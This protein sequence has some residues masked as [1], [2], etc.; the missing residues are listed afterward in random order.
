MI[1]KLLYASTARFD[2]GE[3]ELMEL[4]DV[5]RRNNARDAISGLLLYY[6][7]TFLQLLEGESDLVEATHARISKDPRHDSL[8]TLVDDLYPARSFE[9]WTMGFIPK[10]T[11][12][13]EQVEG[14]DRFLMSGKGLPGTPEADAVLELIESFR[15]TVKPT[16]E[17]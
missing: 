12:L 15:A 16:A 5:S 1:R 11:F 13:P 8:V 6:R 9:S 17:V 14:F 3:A 10:T 7:Q 2:F 4:L